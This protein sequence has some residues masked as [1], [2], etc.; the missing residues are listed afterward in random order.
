MPYILILKANFY[1]FVRGYLILPRAILAAFVIGMTRG[2]VKKFVLLNA[3]P[4]T[5]VR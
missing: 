5:T 4:S 2:A 3:V 1:F